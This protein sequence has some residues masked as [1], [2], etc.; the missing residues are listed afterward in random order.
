MDTTSPMILPEA[1]AALIARLRA[2]GHEAYIVGGSV[3]D[4]LRGIPPH[5]YDM[6]TDATPE[7]MKTVFHDYRLIETGIKH[8][9]VTVLVGREPYE[10]TTYR[11]D[12]AYPDHRHPGDVTFTRSLREDLA[13]R[14]FTVNAIAYAPE[15]GYIDPFGG[16]ADIEG[17]IL[18]AVGNPVER[19]TEDAL[20]ILRALRFASV[21]GYQIEEQTAAGARACKHLLSYV[22][23]ERVG[24]EILKLLVGDSCAEVLRTYPD[25]LGECL[26][27]ILPMLDCPQHT[28]YHLFGVWE[29]TVRVVTGLAKDPI[30]RFAGL[31]HDVAKPACRKTDATGQD[32]FKG[33]PEKGA[34]IA[35]RAAK[36]LRFDRA[37]RE[38][39]VLLVRL[40]DE[41]FA[42]SE[43]RVLRLLSD[44]GYESFLD[45]CALREADNAAQNPE[46]PVI[47]K[48]GARIRQ[49][50]EM[51]MRLEGEGACYRLSDLK[52]S[53]GDI[54]KETSL[55]G[56]AVG[57]ALSALLGAVMDG[58]VRNEHDAL[59]VYL[60]QTLLKTLL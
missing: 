54:L 7:E 43:A 42:P 35:E 59:L 50:R 56:V 22:S 20:R 27:D 23:R 57:K 49:I 36:T 45:W 19:F 30:L 48:E 52:I 24:D 13:R 51:G 12:G 25:I 39:L 31:Y 60:R 41:R 47:R 33:H 15:V 40:H 32:H 17:G 58:E 6:A 34:E 53:G 29:H 11:V 55:R 26:G 18:R 28:P 4:A 9:T 16:I 37:S 10:I 14:D 44:I 21:L 46:N 3:R 2:A 38:R 8:G 1:V 5:D